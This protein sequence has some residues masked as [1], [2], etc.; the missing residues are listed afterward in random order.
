[1]QK[2][3]YQKELICMIMKADRLKI[4][5]VGRQSGHLGEPVL[6][7]MSKGALLQSQEELM[8]QMNQK[9]VCWRILSCQGEASPF[10]LL[11]PS[12]D[13][14][15]PMHIM[16][17]NLF[18]LESTELNVNFIQNT[19]KEIPRIMFNQILQPSQVDRKLTTPLPLLLP[20]GNQYCHLIVFFF[21]L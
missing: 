18:F 21:L 7:L 11:R 8:L 10:V 6:Q 20:R 5:R 15:R 4:C 17:I 1:M 12:A 16:V 13:W 14:I 3:T 2:D 19:F 9:A